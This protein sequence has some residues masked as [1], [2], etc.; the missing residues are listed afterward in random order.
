MTTNRRRRARSTFARAAAVSCSLFLLALAGA[1]RPRLDAAA[2]GL[3]RHARLRGA[4]QGLHG[5]LRRWC[6]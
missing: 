6:A 3:A 1:D 4:G 2:A 5:V